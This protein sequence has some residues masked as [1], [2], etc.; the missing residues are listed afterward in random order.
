MLGWLL[1]VP[2]AFLRWTLS[3][4]PLA[5]SV[6]LL[7]RAYRWFTKDF[8]FWTSRDVPG[9]PPRLPWGVKG[10]LAPPDLFWVD[11][12]LYNEHSDRR[13]FGM[14]ELN[15]PVLFVRDLDLIRAITIK[16]FDH[17]VDRR[18]GLGVELFKGSLVFM[19]GTEWKETRSVLT[20]IF[21][22]GKLKAMHQMMLDN[23]QNL[24]RYVKTQMGEAGMVEVK[25]AFGRFTIDNI[26]ACAFGSY[27]NSFADP[28]CPFA[29]NMANL[30]GV[31]LLRLA[32]AWAQTFLP[33]AIAKWVPDLTA[34]PSAFFEELVLKQIARRAEKPASTRDFLQL[35]IDATDKSGRRV[36]SDDSVVKQSA[37]FVVAG[38]DTSATLMTFAAYCLALD[39][40]VQQR[41]QQEVDEVLAR[42]GGL[43]YESVQ[44]MPYL[45]RVVSETLRLYPPAT[46]LERVCTRDYTLPGTDAHIPVGTLVFI[47][48]FAT[49]RNPELYPEPLKFDPDRFLPEQKEQRHP[50]AYIP[51]GSGPRNCIAMRFALFEA[52]LA[53]VS[54]LREMTLKPTPQTPPHPAPLDPNT[55]LTTPKDKKMPLRVVPRQT[56]GM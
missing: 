34:K 18:E 5:V 37:M 23:A 32:R 24:V 4:V 16:D 46:R 26:A 33:H 28:H 31:R 38:F 41:L 19:K 35:L 47:P 40:D 55:F 13:Y 20:P 11:F 50:C 45:D 22:S 53:L 44:D 54:L 9:P 2:L 36:L 42:H 3:P 30:L 21:S 29:E 39:Q 49:H 48:V 1:T 52:K 14:F 56:A 8:D 6:V 25:D 12:S 51:F 10:G 17:F 27:C 15:R 7:V 43:T